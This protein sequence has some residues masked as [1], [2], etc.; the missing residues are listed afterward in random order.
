M[1]NIPETSLIACCHYLGLPYIWMMGRVGGLT[2][3]GERWGRVKASGGK[4]MPLEGGEEFVR[5]VRPRHSHLY[6]VKVPLI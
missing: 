2:G 1:S 3:G 4:G 5:R 6:H